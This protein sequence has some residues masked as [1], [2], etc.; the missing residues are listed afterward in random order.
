MTYIIQHSRR[1]QIS[2]GKGGN[3]EDSQERRG[4]DGYPHKYQRVTFR[5]SFSP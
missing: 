4:Q 3:L 2:H 5:Q 1:S